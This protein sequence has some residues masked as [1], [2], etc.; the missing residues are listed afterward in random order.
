VSTVRTWQR[1]GSPVEPAMAVGALVLA[2]LTGFLVAS[3]GVMGFAAVLGLGFALVV[4][5]WPFLGLLLFAGTLAIEELLVLEGT[6]GR[7]PGSRLLGTMVFG[8]WMAG[9]LLRR[10]PVV[11]LLKSPLSVTAALFFAFALSSTLWAYW[12]NAAQRG[13]L[14][15]VMYIA[16]GLLTF[17]LVRSWERLDRVI[18][19]LVLGGTAAALITIE[20]AVVGGARRAGGDV[21]GGINTTSLILVTILPLAFYLLRSRT[22]TFWRV[23][24]ITYI[25]VGVSATVVTYSRMS[26]LVLPIILPLLAFHTIAGRRGRVPIL[27]AAVAAFGVGLY[28]VPTERLQDRVA[29]IVPYI[30]QTLGSD[31]G[32][33]QAS[34]RGFHL[35]VGLAIARDH[36]LIGAGFQNFGHLFRDEYQFF[37]PGAGYVWYS[38]RSPHSAHIGIL[39]NL[40]IVGLGLWLALLF[41]AGLIPA[42]KAWRR[43][44]RARFW[45][46]HLAAQAVTYAL[47]LQVFV[48]GFYSNIQFS[49]LL[50]ILLGL[51]G[52]AYV[53]ARADVTNSV[54][55]AQIYQQ[56]ANGPQLGSREYTR[57][58]P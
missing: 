50:W 49:K 45:N 15:L 18:K 24:G 11:P 46:A 44:A 36:P 35:K 6:G 25:A 31:T 39:A 52:A 28:A 40:G 29:T 5:R 57:A 41:G 56:G 26:L 9:K 30:Q 22:S 37:V 43:M 32:I 20:Q 21:A 33:V 19:A 16:L 54:H 3:Q 48:Y 1:R 10:E 2:L 4:Y 42:V 17:D 53:L 8:A 47:G 55:G 58:I 12:P 7:L 34:E 38:P 51:A 14:I 27:A 23:L 13:A